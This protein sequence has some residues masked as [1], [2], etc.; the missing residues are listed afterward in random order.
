MKILYAY[1]DS[2]EHPTGR[3]QR[4]G[5]RRC[6]RLMGWEL[7]CELVGRNV[8]QIRRAVEMHHPDGLVVE[9]SFCP[10]G[11]SATAFGTLPVVYLDCSVNVRAGR[12]WK[13]VY[14]SESIGWRGAQELLRV[15][16]PDSEFAY[17]GYRE[18]VPWSSLRARGFCAEIIRSGHRP[19]TLAC[20]RGESADDYRQRLAAW[21]CGLTRKTAV[22]AANDEMARWVL[23]LLSQAGRHV[24][25]DAIVLGVDNDE[26]V[27][28]RVDPPLTSIRLDNERAGYLSVELLGDV[29]RGRSDKP[30]TVKID[31]TAVISRRST[32][33]GGEASAAVVEASNFIR[34]RAT[35]G[36]SVRDVIERMGVSPRMAELCYRRATGRS[37]A[38]DI[39][40]VRFEE[41]FTLLRE[42]PR[43]LSVLADMCG[44]GSAETFRRAF[45]RRTG[46]SVREWCKRNSQPPGQ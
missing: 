1:A 35:W 46:L 41:V 7:V 31:R 10:A 40:L 30:T 3:L 19:V 39:Q 2:E 33:G 4:A 12:I 24:P 20:R 21:V 26:E 15:A 29:I 42:G 9:A 14:D 37:I 34:E 32:G 43:S 38:A 8:G 44:F 25:A 23:E 27:C 18:T 5:A 6:A 11:F 17:V 22:M 28:S 36:I 45:R 16:S 13:V